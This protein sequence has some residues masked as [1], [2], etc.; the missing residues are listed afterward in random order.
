MLSRLTINAESN[1]MQEDKYGSRS[2]SVMDG[3]RK[4]RCAD[5]SLCLLTSRPANDVPQDVHP[6]T[7]YSNSISRISA[8]ASFRRKN[9]PV[10]L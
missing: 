1:G 4:G 9:T 8:T 2:F 6:I 10:L 3:G 7:N 5:S